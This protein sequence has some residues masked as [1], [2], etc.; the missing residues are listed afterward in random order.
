M[1][2]DPF[3]AL[4]CFRRLI[5]GTSIIA[6]IRVISLAAAL[7]ASCSLSQIPERDLGFS[8]VSRLSEFAG[9][10][11]NRGETEVGQPAI[12]LSGTIWRDASLNHQTIDTVRITA[13]SSDSLRATAIANSH[14]VRQDDFITGRDFTFANGRITIRKKTE[15]S[16]G[17]PSG[18][19][20]IGVARDA[21]TLGLDSDG[22][23]RVENTTVLAGTRS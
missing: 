14:M 11:L 12:Y 7:C 2:L 1:R 21:T 10:Y 3:V 6:P 20:F 17:M 8:N 4:R 13:T 18:N 22:N 16:A 19:V 5:K 15:G 23:G 9:C